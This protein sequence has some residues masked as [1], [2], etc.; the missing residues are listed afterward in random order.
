MVTYLS[1]V[2]EGYQL[3]REVKSGWFISYQ[4]NQQRGNA[5]HLPFDKLSWWRHS[6]LKLKQSLAG[7]WG[8]YVG[9]SV[10]GVGCKRS[11]H[12]GYTESKRTAI[13]SGLNITGRKMDVVNT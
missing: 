8:S 4:G 1:G 7:V 12:W 3:Y 10:M 5:S 9:G 13:L 6:D 2:R 11:Q